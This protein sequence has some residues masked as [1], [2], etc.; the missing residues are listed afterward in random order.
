MIL[1]RKRQQERSPRGAFRRKLWIINKDMSDI[2]I[3]RRIL[4]FAAGADAGRKDA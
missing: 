1:R 4:A 2:S 3:F